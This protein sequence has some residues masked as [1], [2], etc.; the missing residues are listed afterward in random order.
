MGERVTYGSFNGKLQDECLKR[1]NF[2]SLQKAQAVIGAWRDH[3]NRVRPH[4]SSAYRPPAPLSL[5][6]FAQ[7]LP[8]PAAMQQSH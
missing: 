2:C 1:G 4:L 7:Q 5:L 8:T 6:A 3:Y